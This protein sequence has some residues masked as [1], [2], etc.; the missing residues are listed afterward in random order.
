VDY[1]DG[2]G[3]SP[4]EYDI[5]TELSDSDE[6]LDRVV[7]EFRDSDSGDVLDTATDQTVDGSADTSTEQL[8]TSG[9]PNRR[10]SYRI[11]VTVYDEAGNARTVERTVSGSG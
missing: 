4:D 6:G 9:G 7:Y 8:R 1:E 5:E 11:V 3:A 10:D 2:P